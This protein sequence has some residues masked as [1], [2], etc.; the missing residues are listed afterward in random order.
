M[1]E[2]KTITTGASMSEEKPYKPAD[3]IYFLMKKLGF[4]TV[5][6]IRVV[7]DL[8][9]ALKQAY[10]A[11]YTRGLNETTDNHNQRRVK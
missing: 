8:E 3:V 4:D 1:T 11:G 6:D 7:E 5:K 2:P 9:G 10:V